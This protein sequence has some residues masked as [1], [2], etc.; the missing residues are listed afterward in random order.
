VKSAELPRWLLDVISAVPSAGSGVHKW[1]YSTAR[2]LHAHR[3]REEIIALL[4]STTAGCGRA[5][6]RREIES[7]VDSAKQTA[8]QPHNRQPMFTT[9]K[10]KWSDVD[11]AARAKIIAGGYG[12]VDLWETSPHRIEDNTQHTEQIIDLL[13]PGNPL[14]CCGS[15]SYSF[16][17]KPREDWRGQMDSLQLIVPSPMSA[18]TGLTKDGKES[19]H[20]LNN[21]GARRFLVVEF[22]HGTTDEHAA[23]L[24]H[25]ASRAPLVLA[26]HSGG[27]SM[28]GWFFCAGQTEDRL[29]RFM[30]YAVTLGGDA[31]T[32]TRSQ[33]VRMPD[34]T[35]DNGKRQTVYFFNPRPVIKHESKGYY[36]G[37]FR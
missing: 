21:T 4:E 9:P 27:K 26:V 10:T 35:R 34:G 1:L 3:T 31:A 24:L 18:P 37:N 6:P 8:W 14:L 29:H 7:A 33:F 13:F 36:D 17:T 23:I 19:A 5:V 15:S 28:H 11:E 30:E 12:L 16:D 2:Q 25:L 32:W 22:D 20:S